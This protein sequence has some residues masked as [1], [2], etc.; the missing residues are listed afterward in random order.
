MYAKRH[1]FKLINDKVNVLWKTYRIDNSIEADNKFNKFLSQ[2]KHRLLSYSEVIIDSNPE[3][4]DDII[5]QFK[6]KIEDKIS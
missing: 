5:N 6:V 4:W 3:S 2:C 1:I